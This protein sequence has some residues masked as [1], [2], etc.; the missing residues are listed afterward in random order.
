MY[1][2]TKDCHLQYCQLVHCLRMKWLFSVCLLHACV[3]VRVCSSV[4]I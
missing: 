2:F 1:T 3:N 4:W